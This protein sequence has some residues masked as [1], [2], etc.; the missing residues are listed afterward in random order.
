MIFT[1]DFNS[2]FANPLLTV[3]IIILLALLVLMM[4]PLAIIL[5][6]ILFFTWRVRIT[7]E[8]ADEK[9]FFYVRVFGIKIPIW[10]RK[11]K[12]YRINRY[13]LKK[14]AE[15][16]RRKALKE[17]K[18]AEKKAAQKKNKK[19][20]KKDSQKK[21]EGKKKKGPLDDLKRFYREY[22]PEPADSVDYLAG[23]I[24]FFFPTVL[25]HAHFHAARIKIKV[26]GPDAASIALRN[27]A[28][29]T[30]LIPALAFIERHSHLHGHRRA[31]IDV[32][33]D[34][35]S[36]EIKYDVKLG[37][38][39]SVG[40]V[41]L[42]LIRSLIRIVFGYLK[43]K[44]RTAQGAPEKADAPKQNGSNTQT[45]KEQIAMAATKPGDQPKA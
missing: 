32:S 9:V 3:A 25:G 20:E 18:K 33:P 11:P 42:I 7:I 29:Y 6:V 36:E 12:K 40:A 23:L 28:I 19:T 30:A 5:A 1:V 39:I 35:L 37:F 27:T 15:R 8:S 44:P 2:I 10:P 45:L 41:I 31:D 22:I 38:S 24:R 13:T 26:G 21:P 34:Y 4:I 16:D 14:I 43:I 17:A